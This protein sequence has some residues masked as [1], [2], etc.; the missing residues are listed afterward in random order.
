MAASRTLRRMDNILRGIGTLVDIVPC[1]RGY[2]VDF[3]DYLRSDGP[4]SGSDVGV[5]DE[6]DVRQRAVE[7]LNELLRRRLE[8][9]EGDIERRR[10]DWS[11]A[12]S[13]LIDAPNGV[14]DEGGA[15]SVPLMP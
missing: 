10:R 7:A 12:L 14:N 4:A 2:A 11:A 6:A 8:Q 9:T 5:H 3:D 15:G 1:Q 13:G